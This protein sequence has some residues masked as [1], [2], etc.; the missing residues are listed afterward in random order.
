MKYVKISVKEL[1]DLI[2][3][4]MALSDLYDNGVA[5]WDGFEDAYKNESDWLKPSD[6]EIV[7]PYEIIN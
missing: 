6:E 2:R 5:E 7:K 3:D 1:A 4:S